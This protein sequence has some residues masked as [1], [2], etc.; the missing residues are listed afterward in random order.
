MN[1]KIILI[2]IVIAIGAG[3]GIYQGFIRKEA[4]D[5]TLEKVSRGVIVQEI[6]ETG[7]VKA[8][9]EI[10]L[11]FQ[12]PGRIEKIYVGIG[13][14]VRAGQNLAKLDTGQ[15][16][17]QLSEFQAAL[18]LSRIGLNQLLAGTSAEEIKLAETAVA[19][20][21]IALFNARQN[22]ED[23]K[24][25]ANS[26]LNQ[27][28]EDGLTVLDTAYLKLSNALNTV[29]TIE[30]TYFTRLDQESL[31]V[32]KKKNEIE[33]ALDNVKFH[34]GIARSDKSNPENIIDIAL[35][36]MENS[37]TIGVN[38]LG[39]IRDI[40]E[41]PFY[42]NLVSDS[43]KTSLDIERASINT[44][45][46]SIVNSQQIISST[47]LTNET[48]INSARAKVGSA[49]GQV[50]SAKDA[51]NVKKAGPRQLDIDMH[52]ARIKQ[53]QAKND[54]LKEQIEQ[55]L[56]KS[57]I[58]GKVTE[59]NK[60]A[61]E[62]IQIIDPIV[63]LISVDDFQIEVDI[64]E[65]DV[66]RV[67]IGYPV[68]IMPIAFPG[69]I[70]QGK[71]ISI[72]PTEKLIGRV[73]YYEVTIGFEEEMPEGLKPGMT[74]DIR[75][76]TA[77]KENVL[78]IP[79]DAIQEKNDKFIVQVFKDGLIQEREIEIGLQGEDDMIEVVFGLQEGEE[80]VIK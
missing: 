19:N 2:I 27:A 46:T 49:E 57:P 39:V 71:V 73:V 35:A 9:E 40:C 62:T 21:E 6:S 59:I 17:I 16:E 25:K 23:V 74:A 78:I 80:V 7:T 13:Q 53:A 72:N 1:K 65:E 79:D 24:A 34:I 77:S 75:I 42:R 51:L 33:N 38:A 26:D 4:Q 44:T 14:T 20:N 64:Y 30:R 11:S 3:F 48:S 37:L 52:N 54:L 8:V 32:R 60:K 67:S 50:Q 43:D 41:T 76:I 22:L 55:A 18:E 68:E 63:S 45:L 15:L 29:S 31:R 69:Q 12:N 61:G 10:S 58:Q 66:V 5:L 56:L 47:K 36:E 28:Y 70:F